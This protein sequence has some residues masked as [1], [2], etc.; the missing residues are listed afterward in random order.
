MTKLRSF[1]ITIYSVA[2]LESANFAAGYSGGSM[3]RREAMQKSAAATSLLLG[4]TW[5]AEKAIASTKKATTPPVQIDDKGKATL[6][7]LGLGAWAWG[8]SLFW[9]YSP[10]EDAE[11]A[12]VFDYAVENGVGF[13][14][15]AELYGIGRSESLIKNFRASW[16]ENEQRVSVA[17]K[18]AALPW[19][20]RRSDVVAA[21]KASVKRLGRPIDLYQIHFPN[22]YA[23][24]QYWDGLGDAFEAGLV[25]SVGVSNYGS[26]ALRACHSKLAERGIPLSSN[27]IQLSL[28]YRCP[29]ENGLKATCDELGVST[30]A[31]S[32]LGLGL[33]TGKYDATHFP[34]GPRGKLAEQLFGKNP[35]ASEKLFGTMR[36]SQAVIVHNTC[37]V[38]YVALTKRLCLHQHRASFFSRRKLQAAT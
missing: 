19:R 10:K 5:N 33:L 23:N 30:I 24:E 18:F 8:D 34:T 2:A 1:F 32:P 36:V 20:T 12:Q 9:G 27:Q 25:K 22:A 26:A 21:A 15:T 6:P 16:D 17:T 14:D 31:Y 38:A 28:L 7:P 4:P 37:S 13:F 35:S 29:L 11:L 3:P